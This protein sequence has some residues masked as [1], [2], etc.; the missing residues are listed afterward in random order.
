MRLTGSL[1][2]TGLL[3]AIAWVGALYQFTRWWR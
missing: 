1:A 3:G 2:I